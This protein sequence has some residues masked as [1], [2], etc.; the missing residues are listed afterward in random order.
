MEKASLILAAISAAIQV[1]SALYQAFNGDGEIEETIRKF[2]E[3]NAELEQFRKLAQIDSVEGTIFGEDAFGNFV[4]NL[5]VAKDA[6]SDLQASQ[7]AITNRK[8]IQ[9][10]FGKGFADF[11]ESI[12]KMRVK[13]KDRNWLGELFNGGDEYANLGSLFP[14]LFDESGKVTLEGLQNLQNSDVWEQLSERD[15]ELVTSMIN[16]W[17]AYNAAVEATEKYLSDV[18]GDLGG[19]LTD[20]LLEAFK[21][22]TD[23]AEAFGEA[24]GKILERLAQDIVNMA[25]IQPI[26]DKAEADV[27]ELQKKLEAGEITYD[28]YLRQTKAVVYE[29]ANKA[30]DLVDDASEIY[31]AAGVGQD[32]YSSSATSKGFQTMSQ[33]TGSELNGRFTDIQGQVHIIAEAVEFN[34]SMQQ[35]QTL[36]LQS[37]SE[38]LAAIKTDTDSIEK[39]TRALADIKGDI[40]AMRRTMD[41]GGG[42]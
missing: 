9:T 28:E 29:A 17:E 2:A 24:T 1:V 15:R 22:G 31:E 36:Y 37:V 6:L 19:D 20:A 16:D 14:A 7:D 40:S 33:E 23:A 8:S 30:K 41:N 5:K 26:L 38:T 42:I 27:L 34:K 11:S 13:T 21:N 39:H 12:S 4:N 32:S 3:L 10:I 18:F 35:Q 25:L